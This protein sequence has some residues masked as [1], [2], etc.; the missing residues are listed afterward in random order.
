MGWGGING[1]T[2]VKRVL[3]WTFRGTVAGSATATNRPSISWYLISNYCTAIQNRYQL[4]CQYFGQ[5]PIPIRLADSQESLTGIVN[6]ILTARAADPTADTLG[7]EV[8]IDRQ[9]YVL[10]W[11]TDE[12][13]AIVEG[14]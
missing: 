1:Y 2:I 5:I 12:K 4:I 14:R 6:Q 7:L 9:I 10:Y 13:I 8:E 3:H 11:L